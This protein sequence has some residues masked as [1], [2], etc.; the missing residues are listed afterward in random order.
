M[1]IH[2]QTCKLWY[3]TI[4]TCCGVRVDEIVNRYRAIFFFFIFCGHIGQE[5]FEM[6][7]IDH[8]STWASDMDVGWEVVN[9]EFDFP[10]FA[11]LNHDNGLN[12]CTDKWFC[13]CFQML[14]SSIFLILRCYAARESLCA[15]GSS[16][17]LPPKLSGELSSQATY[18]TLLHTELGSLVRPIVSAA[19]DGKTRWCTDFHR[20]RNIEV[21]EFFFFN[22]TL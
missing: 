6:F 9:L 11:E 18:V 15:S 20:R 14:K 10:S 1:G 8:D 16:R 22:I 3:Q 19:T 13:L 5:L 17:P 2:V 4:A 7:K 12:R 21:F